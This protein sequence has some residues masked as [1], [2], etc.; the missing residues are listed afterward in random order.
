[1]TAT[2][3][4]HLNEQGHNSIITTRIS[5]HVRYLLLSVRS[6]VERRLLLKHPCDGLFFCLF[7]CLFFFY[8]S[9]K[10]NR[11]F[12]FLVQTK[13]MRETTTT[14]IMK[15]SAAGTSLKESEKKVYESLC[16][17]NNSQEAEE[18]K[19]C[20]FK[21]CRQCHRPQRYKFP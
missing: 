9:S 1:M 15:V 19:D 18:S 20:K 2:L 5:S 21:T 16:K 11:K 17:K 13:P 10:R 7:V 14:Y 12:R 4:R 8:L 3:F 6:F